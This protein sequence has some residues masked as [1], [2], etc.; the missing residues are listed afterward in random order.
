MAGWL[1]RATSLFQQQQPPPLDPYEVECECGGKVVGVRTLSHQKRPCPLCDR[2][3]FVLPANVYP[4]TKPKSDPKKKATKNLD[5]K[6]VRSTSNAVIDEAPPPSP[7]ASG[8]AGGAKTAGGK[9]PGGKVPAPKSLGTGR[10]A[11]STPVTES[12]ILREPRRP[13]FTRLRLLAIGI[14]VMSSL[15]ITGLWY[16]HRLETAKATVAQAA[17]AG[18]AAILAHD[19]VKAARELKRAQLAV[20]VIG[21]TDPTA[22]EIRRQ[23]REA[24][25][26]AKLASSTLTE[27]LEEMLATAKTDSSQMLKM[28]SVDQGAW[29]IF[30]ARVT[31][32][33]DDSNQYTIDFPMIIGDVVVKIAI[34][35]PAFRGLP[36]TDE[37]GEAP[38]VIFAAQ[39]EQLSSPLG[40]PPSSVLTLNGQTA[41]L[42]SSY[43]NYAAAGYRPF[44][45]E[46]ERS[47]RML[48]ERQLDALQAERPK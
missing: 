44:D 21:R 12:Q 38:R 7:A 32:S 5:P 20:D 18:M 48:L 46:S 19:F 40:E 26:L 14:L 43:D 41:F 30:D 45:E 15:T 34:A 28:S 33:E 42:W 13:F 1:S 25:A 23:S 24:T 39:L 29:L 2:L 3:V 8:K 35:A 27:F 16:R 37:S 22:N 9:V 11:E 47:T 10:A 31:I 6:V 36:Q 17:D 4:Q